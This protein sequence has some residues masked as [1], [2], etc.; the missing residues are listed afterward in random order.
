MK[1]AMG[2]G[3]SRWWVGCPLMAALLRVPRMFSGMAGS[4]LPL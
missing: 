1:N 4:F 3:I 2:N